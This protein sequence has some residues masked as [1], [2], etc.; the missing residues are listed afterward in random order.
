MWLYTVTTAVRV[1]A[2]CL[3]LDNWLVRHVIPW[4]R[5]A[6]LFVEDGVGMF[7]RL[8]DGTEV[9]SGA[10]TRIGPLEFRGYAH[11]RETL[12]RIRA[13]CRQARSR[14]AGVSPPPRYRPMLHVPWLPLLAMLAVF[15]AFSWIAFAVDVL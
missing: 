6:G 9:K 8:D 10:Y 1:R 4:E 11:M 12:G 14:H 13:D 3:V 5:F 15:E 7:A 2:D